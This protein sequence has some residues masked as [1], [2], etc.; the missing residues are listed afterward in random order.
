MPMPEYIS[1]GTGKPDTTP[2][3]KPATKVGTMGRIAIMTSML[4]SMVAG[5]VGCTPE[6][7]T[8]KPT[9]TPAL[10]EPVIPSSTPTPEMPTPEPTALTYPVI[11]PISIPEFS[12]IPGVPPGFGG[13]EMTEFV[14]LSPSTQEILNKEGYAP[15]TYQ[16]TLSTIIGTGDARLCVTP[17]VETIYN[18]D[19]PDQTEV[20]IQTEQGVVYFGTAGTDGTIGTAD[21][22]V[23]TKVLS[24][25]SLRGLPDTV[26][27]LQAVV[28]DGKNPGGMGALRFL[29]MQNNTI[30]GE[31]PAAFG[32]DDGIKLTWIDDIPHVLVNG[33]ELPIT[34]LKEPE[35]TP[36]P[37]A[38]VFRVGKESMVEGQYNQLHWE[39]IDQELAQFIPM[40]HQYIKDQGITVPDENTLDNNG[41]IHISEYQPYGIM[42]PNFYT[43]TILA[44]SMLTMP[45]G[46]TM[47]VM[48]IPVRKEDSSR[49]MI[50]NVAVEESPSYWEQ[51]SATGDLTMEYY[52]NNYNPNIIFPYFANSTTKEKITAHIFLHADSPAGAQF[53]DEYPQTTLILDY[54]AQKEYWLSDRIRTTT[55]NEYWASPNTPENESDLKKLADHLELQIMPTK[56]INPVTSR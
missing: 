46:T 49:I 3:K 40:L 38:P 26:T 56:Y 14:K 51:I 27:C 22:D 2:T 45:D 41:R 42:A 54:N 17:T 15:I 24:T 19:L 21:D 30:I 47:R 44:Y 28:I 9:D 48:H 7:N 33:K 53:L 32:P 50:L 1:V 39:T 5:T 55:L 34:I 12:A 36:T 16:N 10:T 31:A 52:N 6:T 35:K 11:E 37:E 8:P 4:G 13:T 23:Y 25:I 29:L 18:P 20:R 43:D